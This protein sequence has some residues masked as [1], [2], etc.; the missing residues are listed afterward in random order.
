M[1]LNV[2]GIWLYLRT[3]QKGPVN[4]Y[5][6]EQQKGGLF[7]ITEKSTFNRFSYEKICVVFRYV[8]LRYVLLF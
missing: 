2:N 5:N 7:Q 8:C 4:Q 1:L 3:G 6:R